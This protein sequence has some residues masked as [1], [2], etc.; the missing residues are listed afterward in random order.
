ML[1]KQKR[2]AER[3]RKKHELEVRAKK[4]RAREEKLVVSVFFA[5]NR[6]IFKIISRKSG[7]VKTENIFEIP[8]RFS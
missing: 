3:E 4:K 7:K 1:R 5:K 2:Q 6:K 8:K